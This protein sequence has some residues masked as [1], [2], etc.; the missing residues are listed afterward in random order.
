[1][2]RP[3]TVPNWFEMTG[4]PFFD[5]I[6]APLAGREGFRALQIGCF[7]GDAS[8]WLLSNIVTGEGAL[9]DDVDTWQGSEDINDIDFCEVERVYDEQTAPFA[10]HHAKH[11]LRSD[12]FLR[13]LPI[14]PLY[15][16][17]Y[18][19]GDH[20]AVGCLEDA[21]GSWQRLKV[22]GSL[23]FDDYAWRDRLGRPLHAPY[24]AINAFMSL[25]SDRCE[26]V[27]NG[28]QLWLRRTA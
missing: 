16:F 4:R 13:S 24:P 10:A 18:I 9:L 19:D 26:L 5:A 14:V 6:L 12:E 3:E 11:K 28:A 7:A 20:T 15:D 23:A 22:G 2:T 25:Y 8:T 21:V 27:G 1:M 17:A